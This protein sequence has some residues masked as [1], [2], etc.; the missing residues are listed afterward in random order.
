MCYDLGAEPK[1]GFLF[2][3]NMHYLSCVSMTFNEA[4]LSG[5]SFVYMDFRFVW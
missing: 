3:D 1:L 4:V 5:A 2:L